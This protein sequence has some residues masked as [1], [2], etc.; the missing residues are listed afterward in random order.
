M[1]QIG[2]NNLIINSPYS[3]PARHWVFAEEEQPL[4]LTESRRQ[5]G[6]MVADTRVRVH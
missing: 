5:A 3:C 6:Y 2:P 4:D 1:S